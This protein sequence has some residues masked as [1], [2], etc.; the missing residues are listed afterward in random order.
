MARFHACI[1][2]PK[3]GLEPPTRSLRMTWGASASVRTRPVSRL[4][5]PQLS[6]GVC[7]CPPAVVSE[8]VSNYETR[9]AIE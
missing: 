5:P 9:N 3:K 6:A 2:E 4:I 1:M 7:R 8:V